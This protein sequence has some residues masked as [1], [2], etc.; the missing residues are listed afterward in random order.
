M[1]TAMPSAL[2]RSA[3]VLPMNPAPPVMST[4]RIPLSELEA[5]GQ[6][7]GA[8]HL[9]GLERERV[10][11]LAQELE[12]GDELARHRDDVAPDGVGLDEVQHLA[13]AGP[14]QLGPWSDRLDDLER[15]THDR[16]RL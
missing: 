12:L 4:F 15:S 13:R 1:T 9:D 7:V 14:D 10:E 16:Q 11:I 2:S 5:G 3:S 6:R 8:E